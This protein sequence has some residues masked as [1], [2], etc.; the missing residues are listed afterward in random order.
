MPGIQNLL[1]LLVAALTVSNVAA[2]PL[3]RELPPWPSTPTPATVTPAPTSIPGN[4]VIRPATTPSP[5]TGCTTK[6]FE[7]QKMGA[8]EK[9]TCTYYD[10]YTTVTEYVDCGGCTLQMQQMG[11][12]PVAKCSA[13]TTLPLGTTTATSC[14]PSSSNYDDAATTPSTARPTVLPDREP[15]R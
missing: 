9:G 4:A 2:S 13:A 7:A 15:P 3:K 1:V 8:V 10:S 11:H 12:G 6:L 5:S 14:S